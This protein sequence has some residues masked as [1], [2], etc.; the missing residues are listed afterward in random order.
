MWLFFKNLAEIG[1]GL[2]PMAA[3]LAVLV[4][5]RQLV[6]NRRNQRETTAKATFREY[7]KLAFDHPDLAGGNI[8]GMTP[9]K[10]QKY[11]WF[12]GFF[13]WGVEEVLMFA[14]KDAI[15]HENI[16]QQMLAHRQYFRHDA[17]FQQELLSYSPAVQAFVNRIKNTA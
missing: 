9:E 12:V 4:A 1:P 11:K 8:S 13:L 6:L 3:L 17:A 2:T 5:W 10:F 7:L 16:R 15:W 14:E